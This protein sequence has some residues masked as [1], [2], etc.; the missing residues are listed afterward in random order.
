MPDPTCPFCTLALDQLTRSRALT[1]GWIGSYE[2]RRR[3]PVAHEVPEET[4]EASPD[5]HPIHRDSTG[6]DHV[7]FI[8]HRQG[9]LDQALRT[10]NRDR[11]ALWSCCPSSSWEA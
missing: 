5:P 2:A 6:Y 4:P 9:I 10:W 7:L 3:Q 1:E 11:P 8:A